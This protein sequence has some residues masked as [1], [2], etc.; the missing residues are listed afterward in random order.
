MAI[1]CKQVITQTIREAS[2]NY[3]GSVLGFRVQRVTD[4]AGRVQYRLNRTHGAN[5][6]FTE[7]TCQSQRSNPFPPSRIS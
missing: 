5:F 6:V 3:P 1:V 4:P 7:A 2:L